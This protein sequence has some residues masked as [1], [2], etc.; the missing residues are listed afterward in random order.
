M[1]GKYHAKDSS[2]LSNYKHEERLSVHILDNNHPITKGLADFVIVDETYG[3][4]E[5]DPEVL[6][7]LRTDHP[8]SMPVIG[9]INRYR[10]HQ[11]VYL[12]GGHGPSA[13]QDGNFQKILYQAICWSVSNS[14]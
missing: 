12:Q 9:W 10:G 5:I 4:C 13:F 3:H 1:G 6:P 14:K 7:L 11:I 2:R 8:G